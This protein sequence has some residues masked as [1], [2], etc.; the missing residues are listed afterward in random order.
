[1]RDASR[2]VLIVR[3]SRRLQDSGIHAAVVFE[4]FRY[5]LDNRVFDVFDDLRPGLRFELMRIDIDNQVV[6]I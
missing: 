5:A 1:M 3:P 2:H 4:A 6:V